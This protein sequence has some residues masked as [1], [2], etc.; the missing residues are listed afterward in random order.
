MYLFNTSIRSCRIH[1]CGP[2]SYREIIPSRNIPVDYKSADWKISGIENL[3]LKGKGLPI[4][5]ELN[6]RIF[7]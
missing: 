2:S 6:I 4:P 7:R 3:D 5:F 1:E